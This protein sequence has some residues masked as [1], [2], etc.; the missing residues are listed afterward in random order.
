MRA[1]RY[2]GSAAQAARTSAEE[3]RNAALEARGAI[4]EWAHIVETVSPSRLALIT[5]KPRGGRGRG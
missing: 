4:V 2:A 1:A 5:R 3:A